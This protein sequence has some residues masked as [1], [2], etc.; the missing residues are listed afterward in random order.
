[1]LAVRKLGHKLTHLGWL[2]SGARLIA[3]AQTVHTKV[4]WLLLFQLAQLLL[5]LLQLVVVVCT[6][7][8]AR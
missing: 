7:E 4:N 3:L 5:L 1:M 2:A 6:T 8:L